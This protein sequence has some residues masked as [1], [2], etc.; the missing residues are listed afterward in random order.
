MISL[1]ETNMLNQLQ[2]WKRILLHS[3][4]P[5]ALYTINSNKRR[6]VFV[7]I[8]SSYWAAKISEFLWREHVNP[9]CISLHSYDFVRSKY[10]ISQNDIFVVFSH[11]GTKTFSIQAL[12]LAKKFGATTILI[13]GSEYEYCFCPY[14]DDIVYFI[15]V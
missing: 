7:G 4:L 6:I 12:E 8:G 14:T 5:S 11:R 10:L 13:T 1:Y 2:E 9:D 15:L 3:H